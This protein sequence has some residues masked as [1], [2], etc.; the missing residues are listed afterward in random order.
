MDSKYKEFIEGTAMPRQAI[1]MNYKNIKEFD[2]N[3]ADLI[4]A[5]L[6]TDEDTINK[7]FG[8]RN[9]GKRIKLT[10]TSG[11]RC[12]EWERFKKRKT[13]SRHSEGTAVD[14]CPTNCRAELAV[15]IMDWLYKR[16]NPRT[17]WQGGYARKFP[18]IEKGKIV[19]KGFIHKDL[20]KPLGRW[21]Y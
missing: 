15:E 8:A 6:K 17:A 16:D 12:E 21:S 2:A 14:F 1:E 13:P 10:I 20:R 18:T 9:A 19:L 4:L 5:I 11:W 7:E 3:K